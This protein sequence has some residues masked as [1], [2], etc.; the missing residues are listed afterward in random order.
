MA[1]LLA[2]MSSLLWGTADYVGGVVAKRAPALVV[3]ATTQFLALLL[4]VPVVVVTAAW[5][6][7]SG[8]LPWGIA[9]G[10]V[11][12]MALSSFYYALS[13]GT[14]GV[15]S[16]IAATGI[17]VPVTVGLL[18]GERPEPLALVGIV[19][20]AAGIVLAGGPD[21][22]SDADDSS[23][24]GLRPVVFALLAA[25]GFGMIYVLL[26]GGGE[27]SVLM[28]L[29]SQR[30]TSVLVVSLPV[31]VFMGLHGLNHRDLPTLLGVAVGDVGANGL[32]IWSST[33]GLL[34]VTAVFGSL[35]PVV[36]L[37]LARALLGERL[38]R[39][40]S[41]GVGVAMVGVCLMAAAGA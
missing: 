29:V 36:T 17:V 13:I 27:T 4:L 21:S 6:A 3:V 33:L 14:M 12:P 8:Y 39:L 22:R 10:V 1:A 32:F 19:L 18:R 34:S 35:Y 2:L 11:G 37:L 16:P 7:P 40:Q 24:H 25:L 26:A 31:L 9:A 20:A 38:T 15:V 5:E 30:A 41:A 28:T 23:K